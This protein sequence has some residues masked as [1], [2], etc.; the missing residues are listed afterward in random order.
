MSGILHL[1]DIL[2][3]PVP[4]NIFNVGRCPEIK[5]SPLTLYLYILYLSQERTK[6]SIYITNEEL[7]RITGMSKNTILNARAVLEEAG[8][9]S[10]S[11]GSGGYTYILLNPETAKVLVNSLRGEYPPLDFNSLQPD[12]LRSYYLHHAKGEV[13]EGDSGI[14]VRCPFHDDRSP[15]MSIN[16]DNGSVWHCHPCGISGRLIE[17]ETRMAQAKRETITTSEAHKRVRAVLVSVGAIDAT[18]GLPEAKY[19]YHNG[20]GAVVFEVLRY[21]GKKFRQRQPDTDKPGHYVWKVN[22]AQKVLY[23][24]PAVLEA[25]LVI[26]CEGEKDVNNLR[27]LNLNDAKE[28]PV[29]VT[30]C[31]GGASKWRASYSQALKGKRVVI[32][33]DQ[34]FAGRRHAAAVEYALKGIASEV[35]VCHFPDGFKDMTEYLGEHGATDLALLIDGG[36]ISVP[37]A[38]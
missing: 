32:F 24:L 15:S 38:V 8:F 11:K 33:P 4:K 25:E 29:A 19:E 27:L 34:D 21:K 2:Y 7:Q 5:G 14:M 10:F 12:Q 20:N 30:T 3:F 36:W 26:I 13:N 37:T 31:P 6:A 9:I 18:L 35:R 17:F 1:N 22:S 16:L 23:G 28:R